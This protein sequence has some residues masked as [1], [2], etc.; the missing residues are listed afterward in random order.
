MINGLQMT[1]GIREIKR[2]GHRLAL[3]PNEVQVW[4]ADLDAFASSEGRTCGFLSNDEQ[5]RASRFHF[6]RDRRRFMA[7]RQILRLLL[8]AYLDLEPGELRFRYSVHG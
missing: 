3:R 6:E 4:S 8:S 1:G 5:D 7:G 2:L